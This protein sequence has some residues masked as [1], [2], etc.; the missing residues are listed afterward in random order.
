[1]RSSLNQKYSATHRADLLTTRHSEAYE[2][3]QLKKDVTP[4]QPQKLADLL[5]EDPG[6]M[7]HNNKK[8]R[9][10]QVSNGN[11]ARDVR[12]VGTSANPSARCGAP[13]LF[14][15]FSFVT[16]ACSP[17]LRSLPPL[18]CCG[19][20][21]WSG[22]SW[23]RISSKRTPANAENREYILYQFHDMSTVGAMSTEKG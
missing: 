4:N 8:K 23:S 20:T 9:N 18:Y 10:L 16:L 7:A 13:Y 3:A 11:R 1:M 2:H 19:G 12:T 17:L 21:H 22:E 5:T 6:R 15:C 14:C